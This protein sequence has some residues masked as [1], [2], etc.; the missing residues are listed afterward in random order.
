[1]D[2]TEPSELDGTLVKRK[3]SSYANSSTKQTSKYG[4]LS[5]SKEGTYIMIKGSVLQE[6]IKALIHEYLIME[7]QNMRGKTDRISRRSKHINYY[8]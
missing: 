4:S 5:G 7:H 2:T 8:G 3:V 6:D 1:M